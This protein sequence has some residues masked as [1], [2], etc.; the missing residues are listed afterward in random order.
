MNVGDGWGWGLGVGPK[1]TGCADGVYLSDPPVTTHYDG[2][3]G[4]VV[5]R[6]MG[7]KEGSPE[8]RGGPG[9][10]V[11]YFPGCPRAGVVGKTVK[12]C[13]TSGTGTRRR[14]RTVEEVG[15]TGVEE[16]DTQVETLTEG[17][18]VRDTVPRRFGTT[19]G[20]WEP[21]TPPSSPLLSLVGPSGTV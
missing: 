3:S 16:T 5:G 14:G 18:P 1:E 6:G 15:G 7:A 10:M 21:S 12:G 19:V 11:L 2:L 20:Y 4:T 8:G 9:Q 13:V 17:Y